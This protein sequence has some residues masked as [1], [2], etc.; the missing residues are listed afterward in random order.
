MDMFESLFSPSNPLNEQIAR[1]IFDI[2][3]EQGPMMV[4]LDQPGPLL[5]KQFGGIFCSQYQ[6]VIFQRTHS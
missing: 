2:L 3:P 4:I 1:Q 5:A 6:S